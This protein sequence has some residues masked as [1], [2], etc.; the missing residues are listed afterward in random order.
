M[1]DYPLY[2]WN[3]LEILRKAGVVIKQVA[4]GQ[5]HSLFLTEDG[6]VWSCG[7]NSYGQLG[8][9]VGNSSTTIVNLAKIPNLTG[10][11]VIACGQVHSLFLTEGG[12]VWSCGNNNSGQ[13]GRA[14]ADGS[15]TVVN[16]AKIS[17]LTGIKAIACGY[18][19]SFFLTEAG[20]VLSCGSNTYG[21]LGRAVADGS[22]TVVNLAKTTELI[23]IKA[24]ASGTN[25]SLFL[26]EG[27]EVWS[28]GWNNYGQLGRAVANG[29]ATVVNLAKIPNIIGIKSIASGYYHSLIL[30]D[31]G[32]VWSCGENTYGQLGRVEADGSATVVNL[33]KTTGLIGIKAI[34]NGTN[35][36]LFL[37]EGAEVLT[38]GRN[39]NGQL[40]RAVADGST[41]VIN[42]AKIPDLTGIK[43]LAG[44]HYHSLFLIENNEV[45]SCG[46]NNYGQLGRA[47]ADGSAAATNLGKVAFPA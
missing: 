1:A 21:Q 15:A 37:T 6:E 9:V 32:E 10:I 8:Q 26:T 12:E 24:I 41:T 30:T 33:A 28:C 5:S 22:A 7:W 23:G 44:G 47:V 45:W 36:S 43:A 17:N 31:D 38:C 13:L 3:A 39:S 18:M 29:S 20:E 25:H 46:K 27:K 4:G 14:V 34:A 16:L 42:L 40:G 11:R 19:Y 35:H 2:V